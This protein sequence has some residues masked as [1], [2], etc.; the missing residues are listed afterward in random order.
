MAFNLSNS[1]EKPISQAFALRSTSHETGDVDELD[2][3][4]QQRRRVGLS[5][6][7]GR[8]AHRGSETT[9]TLGSTVVNG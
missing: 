4:G 8:V 7:S 1:S 6:R 2:T 9:P 3:G 5:L